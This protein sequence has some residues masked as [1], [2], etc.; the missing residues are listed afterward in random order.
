MI[1]ILSYIIII[2]YILSYMTRWSSFEWYK[3][4]TRQTSNFL[5][6]RMFWKFISYFHFKNNE[7]ALI[8]HK[9][10]IIYINPSRAGGLNQPTLFSDKYF[11]MKKWVWRSQILW[12]FLEYFFNNNHRVKSSLL[13]LELSF[14]SLL[15]GRQTSK[16]RFYTVWQ[17]KTSVSIF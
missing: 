11:S 17:F 10:E 12:L 8:L 4:V 15:Q 13:S 2:T 9:Q 14:R 5:I 16:W 1:I 7:K 3:I 6:R